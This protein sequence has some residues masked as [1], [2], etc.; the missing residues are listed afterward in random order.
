MTRILIDLQPC[1]TQ[2]RFRGMGRYAKNIA[3]EIASAGKPGEVH[4]LLNSAF[5]TTIPEIRRY[6]LGLVPD[7]HIHVVTMLADSQD[8]RPETR[9]RNDASALLRESYIEMI[10]PDVVFCPSFFEGYIDNASLSIHRLSD[11]PV[12]VTMH[13]LIPLTMRDV[14]LQPHPD[15]ERH[16]M[17]KVEEL[18]NAD[19][20][21]AI[22]DFT[23]AE[24]LEYLRYDPSKAVN[25]SEGAE[26]HFRPLNLSQA[27]RHALIRSFGIA[28]RFLF[29]TGGCDARK[30]LER[31]MNAFAAVPL[32]ARRNVQLVIAGKISAIES[33]MLR[34]TAEAAGL[35]KNDLK[36]LGFVSDEELVQLYNLC[37]VMVFP[38]LHEGFGL[39]ALEAMQSGA[40]VIASNLSSL[41]EVIGNRDALF[42]PTSVFD[43]AARLESVLT[44]PEFRQELVKE[45][46]ARARLFSWENSGRLARAFLDGFHKPD[47]QEL[48]WSEQRTRL[49][50]CQKQLLD[51][52]TL[53]SR[54][55]PSPTLSDLTE[56][57]Q[58]LA[59]NRIAAENRLRACPS[60]PDV[61]S[62]R[63]EGPFDSTYSLALVNRH[64]ASAL[65]AQNVHVSLHSSEGPGDIQPDPA[66][67]DENPEIAALHERS[68]EQ[69]PVDA[70]VVTRNMYP[71]RVLDMEARL[72]GLSNYA[73]E[74]TGF[75]FEY[76]EAFNE[77]LQ[78]MTVTSKHVK[79]LL[80]DA[81]VSI[82]I[83]VVGNGIDH[84]NAIEPDTAF[85]IERAGHTFL[86]VS[87]CFPRKGADILLASYGKAFSKSDDVLLVI[88]TF[89]NPHNTIEAQLAALQRENPSYPNVLLLMDDMSDATLKALY[90]QCDTLVA[91][92]RAEGFGLPIAEAMLAG[93]DVITT[94]WSGQMD[95]CTPENAALID[96]SF[97]SAQTHEQGRPLSAWAEP[98]EAHLTE[99]MLT[100]ARGG[101]ARHHRK[102]T[103]T[104]LLRDHTWK[105]VA[106]RTR[107]AAS[108]APR[109]LLAEP[110]LG[111]VSTYFK[112]CGIATYSE[113][114]LNV[115]G[116]PA[117][118]LADIPEHGK[119]RE[120]ENIVRCWREG[121]SDTLAGIVDAVERL[122]IDT[123]VIQFNYGFF[124]FPHF[125][126]V[127]HTLIDKGVSVIVALHATV[128]PEHDP[129]RRMDILVDALARCDR[130]LV[131]SIHDMNRLKAR[132][133]VDNVTLFPHGVLLPAYGDH[134]HLTAKGPV[135]LA[136]YGF[137]LPNKGL[138][139]LIQAAAILKEKEFA[140][141][142]DM[143]NAAYPGDLSRD[144]I[145]TARALIREKRLERHVTLTTDFLQD[146]DILKRL[147][148][149]D[150]IVY[151]Y[152]GT[153]ESASGAV[154]YG[155]AA[156][157][158]VAVS[159]LPIFDDVSGATF[160]LPGTSP[161]QIASGVQALAGKLRANDQVVR[162]TLQRSASW[163]DAHAF[164]VLGR[165]L[166]GMLRGLHRDRLVSFGSVGDN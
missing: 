142:L 9:W 104:S 144:L 82:P 117:I 129:A 149:A 89:R 128:D 143:V 91:P 63:I 64:L 141:R 32:S 146:D 49:D 78:F 125:A 114:L 28:E 139:E 59:A 100:A 13:D 109:S 115:L 156:G 72:N 76:A 42:D 50:L 96:Y 140:F 4:I 92:S 56:T 105:H 48:T 24:T 131:H 99:L 12:V 58:A 111:W 106:Q 98:S 33:A 136:S 8:C 155:L 118:V 27:E 107:A 19:G 35:G 18:T 150:I 57:A 16:Y 21:V 162:E 22:S 164:P 69:E 108:V 46:L 30:N 40:P 145:K 37:E 152:Q 122:S 119:S 3:R 6:F 121:K 15:F 60:L 93:L 11:V 163:R 67:L 77:S 34:Q 112:H 120:P 62:W 101:R 157:S 44:R 138:I 127:L 55:H 88:K 84:W 102:V 81:G 148:E 85:R 61:P 135:R 10:A 45:G 25:A 70:D 51:A 154:R 123:L 126:Q 166:A 71:P 113:H 66:F 47:R 73:W 20:I 90:A 147:S 26:E 116:M 43:M 36:L 130:L 159:P 133:L 124:D 97:A 87:S 79:K 7:E 94:G 161:E 110:R 74:E 39:P 151:P 1:Q 17:A 165:R 41:P 38:S 86:H 132:G 68:L 65:N 75:P 14:Y 29:Y 23:L 134:N 160:R 2:S 158:A 103:D 80:I 95:F 137:F 31:L 5:P 52:L 54:D 153:V 53:L 83:R